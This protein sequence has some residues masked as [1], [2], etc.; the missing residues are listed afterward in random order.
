MEISIKKMKIFETALNNFAF[1]GLEW[2]ENSKKYSCTKK[3]HIFQFSFVLV[4]ISNILFLI[5]DAKT[6]SDYTFEL[7]LC[8]TAIMCGII[9]LSIS[10][11]VDT[12]SN[13]MENCQDMVEES[14]RKHFDFIAET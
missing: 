8:S 6:F 12:F 3:L 14:K 10:S 2:D 4:F 1:L 7:M 9:C 11:N 13:L 5:Y